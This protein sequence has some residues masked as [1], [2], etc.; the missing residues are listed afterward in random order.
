MKKPIANTSL[1][2]KLIEKILAYYDTIWKD[3]PNEIR[4]KEW[5][6]NFNV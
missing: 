5:L 2:D 3:S 4:Q 1:E 6:E